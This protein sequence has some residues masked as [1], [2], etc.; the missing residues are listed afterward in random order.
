MIP[1]NKLIEVEVWGI[2]G[3]TF[4]GENEEGKIYLTLGD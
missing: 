1:N 2:V 3:Y 4:E